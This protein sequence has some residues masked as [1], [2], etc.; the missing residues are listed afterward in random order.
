MTALVLR[1]IRKLKAT[2]TR[3][4]TK[5]EAESL[6]LEEVAVAENLWLKEIQGLLVKSSKFDQLK[7]SLRLIIDESGIYKCNERLRLKHAPLPY[8]S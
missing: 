4:G 6:S 7:V 1:L 2:R 5:E 3:S 8:N